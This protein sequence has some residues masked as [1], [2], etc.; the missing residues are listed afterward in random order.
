MYVY[1]EC[2][3]CTSILSSDL[4]EGVLSISCRCGLTFNNSD[5]CGC[6]L[7]MGVS[8]RS[9]GV[10]SSLYGCVLAVGLSL[11]GVLSFDMP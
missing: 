3:I 8:R 9:F 7:T 10:S 6:V 11:K 4:C 1:D 2:V 5:L